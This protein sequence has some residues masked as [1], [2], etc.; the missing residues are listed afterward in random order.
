MKLCSGSKFE[1]DDYVESLGW[2]ACGDWMAALPVSGEILLASEK[3]QPRQ[4]AGH[5]LSNHTLAWHPIAPIFATGGSDGVVRIHD[6]ATAETVAE[7]KLGRAWIDRLAWSP[8]GNFLAA[9][10]GKEVCILTPTGDEVERI[11]PHRTSVSDLAWNPSA[12]DE[13]ATVCGGGAT[14]WRVCE[15]DPI[16]DFEWGGASLLVTWSADG[17]W[18]VTADQ[19]PSVH[20]Y[21]FT[22]DEP[23]HIQGYE[24]KVKAMA[25]S[26]NSRLLA[27]GGGSLVTVWTCT[28]KRGPENTIPKQLEGHLEICTCLAWH[29]KGQFLATGGED[30]LVFLFDPDRAVAPQAFRQFDCA[31][32][33]I[34]WHPG[35]EEILV[36]TADGEVRMVGI[37]P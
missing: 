12:P 3:I 5:G 7:V 33:A 25:F 6:A 34:A 9:T 1:A 19:T 20:L 22:R 35:G 11:G 26:P 37:E 18:V 36:G 24:S 14:M 29:P 13:L 16:A 8:D 28:G 15:P 27:T 2:S 21:D 17:R 31:V 30:G 4:L 23:L 10:C 32:S